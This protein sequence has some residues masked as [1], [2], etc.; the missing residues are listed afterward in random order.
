MLE[1]EQ[2]SIVVAQGSIRFPTTSS[3]LKPQNVKGNSARWDL[4]RNTFQPHLSLNGQ[5]RPLFDRTE[6]RLKQDFMLAMSKMEPKFCTFNP[7]LKF[8]EEIGKMYE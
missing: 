7:P 1:S 8:R 6:N 5:F 3:V 4:E 2:S